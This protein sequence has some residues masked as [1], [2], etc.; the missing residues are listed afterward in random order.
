MRMIY[1]IVGK[2]VEMFNYKDVVTESN[3]GRVYV[4]KLVDGTELRLQL[5]DNCGSETTG[6]VWYDFDDTYS[7][8]YYRE[9]EVAEIL[10]EVEFEDEES[11]HCDSFD[12]MDFKSIEKYLIQ[13]DVYQYKS[14][15]ELTEILVALNEPVID[16]SGKK[17]VLSKDFGIVFYWSEYDDFSCY[18]DGFL[19][20]VKI[21]EGVK[22]V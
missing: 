3:S 11:N 12:A 16:G 14:K 10:K 19:H 5:H 21:I 8:K 17:S 6:M 9:S 13:E 20:K 22:L 4:C 7:D 18:G 15:D 1:E 2:G